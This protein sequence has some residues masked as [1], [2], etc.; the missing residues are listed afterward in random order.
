MSDLDVRG[1]Y[2]MELI[3]REF[4]NKYRCAM[5]EEEITWLTGRIDYCT[6]Y[7]SGSNN[8]LAKYLMNEII[9]NEATR[10]ARN[11][12]DEQMSIHIGKMSDNL[13]YWDAPVRK[14]LLVEAAKR[15]QANYDKFMNEGSTPQC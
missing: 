14:M 4:E 15:L 12:T 6:T 11:L 5:T 13:K 3:E 10:W 1:K 8:E 7:T 2:I 9:E